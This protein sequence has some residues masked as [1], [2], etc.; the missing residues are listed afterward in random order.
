MSLKPTME[1]WNQSSRRLPRR[2]VGTGLRVG[3]AFA[4]LVLLLAVPVPGR[5]ASGTGGRLDLVIGIN[6]FPAT[7]HPGIDAM[8]ATSYILGMAYRPLTTYGPDWKLTCLLCVELPSLEQGTAVIETRPDGRKAIAV[9]YSLRPDAVWGDGVPVTTADV[10]FSWEVGRHPLTGYANHQLYARDI[11]DLTI[12]DSHRFTVHYDKLSCNYQG[13]NDFALLP[14]HLERPPFEADPA[15]YAANTRY[16]TDPTNPG[17][18]FGPYRVIGI[19]RGSQVMLGPNPT[20]WGT[21][22]AFQR[23]VVRAIE[24]SA[25]LEANLLSGD[26]DYIP[27]EIGLPLDQALALEARHGNRFDIVYKAGLFF[28]HI[29]LNLDNPALADL[30][31]RQALLQA[32]DR[33]TISRKLFAGRQPVAHN[34]VNPLDSVFDADFPH[35]AFDPRQ[36]G[37]L[38]DAAGWNRWQGAV[39]INE[40]GEPLTLSLMTTAGNRSREL[41]EQVLQAQWRQI[42]VEV[43]IDNQPARVLFGQ[44]L[45]ERRFPAMALFAW[46]SAPAN[47]PR[48]TLHSS[49]I[50]DAD[51]RFAGQNYPGLRHPEVDQ[52]LD[53]LEVVCEPA[54]SRALWRRL[55]QL[56]AE[57]LPALPLYYRADAYI[58][59]K[60]LSGVVPTGHMSPSTLWIE[61][62][63]V[64]R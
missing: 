50:P 56:Y 36:A 24:N 46:L 3:S 64:S 29:D 10:R 20:W 53:D 23:I 32:L 9:T 47:I 57:L 43:R 5:A 62:W 49:M 61:D 12:L 39:R 40:R 51:N 14:A 30:R 52:V 37:Q 42:G 6:Q 58:K 63:R 8:A 27:G 11:A 59:P 1:R 44:S 22:P 54:A 7:L 33:E 4:L 35:Y 31:V 18:Y 19:E 25:A 15:S 38:L 45:R 16:Q 17:L 21:A 48:S 55:Q 2:L 34:T 41:V 13:L 26:I 28:E 60:W